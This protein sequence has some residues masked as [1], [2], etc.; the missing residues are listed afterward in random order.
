MADGTGM[1]K[2]L[3]VL[4]VEDSER[5][6]ALLLMYLRRGGYDPSIRRVDT[7]LDLE[8]ELTAGSWDLVVSDF[9]LPGFDAFATMDLLRQSGSKVP[10]I[11]LSA[12]LA[13]RIIEG[14]NA[15]GS[16]FVCKYEM[17][18]IVPIIDRLT[19]AES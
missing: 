4:L 18:Q 15:A 3:K 1:A 9:N 14:I 5:D 17:R 19:R 11:V 16:E 13:P 7:R 2:P 10:L 6:A 8:R 12:E